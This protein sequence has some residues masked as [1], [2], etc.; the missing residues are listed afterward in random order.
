MCFTAAWLARV[1]RVVFGSSM[2]E[3][4]AETRGSQRE[5]LVPAEC[6]NALSGA[7][8]ALSGGVLA[9][10]CLALFREEALHG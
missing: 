10:R 1:G 9:E 5:L 8:L 4:V 2:R 7:P 6:M 3:V